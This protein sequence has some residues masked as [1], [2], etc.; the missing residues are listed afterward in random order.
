MPQSSPR[1]LVLDLGHR[2]ALG[3]EDFLVGQSN[4]AAVALIDRWPGWPGPVALVVGP[5][6]SGKSHLAHVWQHRTGAAIVPAAGLDEAAIGNL[7][8]SGSLIVEDIDK[9]LASEELLFHLCNLAREDGASLLLTS[10]RPAGDLDIG[11]PDLRSRLRA[12]VMVAIEAP[13][14][15]LLGAVLVKHFADRQLAVDPQ[16]ICWLIG[17]IE[18][19]MAAAAGVV[20][21]IDHL[22]LASRRKVTRTLAAEAIAR[23][24]RG[25]GGVALAPVEPLDGEPSGPGSR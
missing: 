5:G 13:D 19:T 6:H 21:A 15:G 11:L 14:D 3:V 16:L 9:G 1:Q 4:A 12:A 23:C 25:D 10:T 24:G 18:R 20:A 7:S 8:A 17:N 2:T 22:A